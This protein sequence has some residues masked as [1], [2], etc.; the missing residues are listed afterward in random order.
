MLHKRVESTIASTL[1]V[2]ADIRLV[3]FGSIPRQEGKTNRTKDLRPK[4]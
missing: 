2:H 4:E 3:P 1:N